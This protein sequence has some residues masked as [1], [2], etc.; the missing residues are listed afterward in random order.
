MSLSNAHVNGYTLT[1]VHVYVNASRHLPVEKT[2]GPTESVFHVDSQESLEFHDWT[3]KSPSVGAKERRERPRTISRSKKAQAWQIVITVDNFSFVAFFL[4]VLLSFLL[5]FISLSFL[6]RF[7]FF[8]LFYP[9]LLTFS[10]REMFLQE[11]LERHP[12]GL[13]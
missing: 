6:S 9:S 7:F 1:Y 3:T 5:F 13:P 4:S 8:Y 11:V 10:A 2:I 12:R